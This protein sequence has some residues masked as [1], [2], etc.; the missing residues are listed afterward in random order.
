[1]SSPG[2][3]NV[4]PSPSKTSLDRCVR[5]RVCLFCNNSPPKYRYVEED[6]KEGL[7]KDPAR[8]LSARP[9]DDPL[10]VIMYLTR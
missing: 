6:L 1:M 2:R 7:G 9:V 3:P 4:F 5:K 10:E 8:V